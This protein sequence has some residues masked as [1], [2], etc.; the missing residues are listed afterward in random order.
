MESMNLFS[1][2]VGDFYMP[3]TFHLAFF[4]C[5]CHWFGFLQYSRAWMINSTDSLYCH[6]ER[7]CFRSF[8][9]LLSSLS[10]GASM[11]CALGL[12]ILRWMYFSPL[13]SYHRAWNRQIQLWWWYHL[14]SFLILSGSELKLTISTF[15]GL[16]MAVSSLPTMMSL[17]YSGLLAVVSF[18]LYSPSAFSAYCNSDTHTFILRSF[19][20]HRLLFW[21]F[22]VSPA[23]IP[24]PS[25]VFQRGMSVLSPP[26][27][28]E[29]LESGR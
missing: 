29:S 9:S 21:V 15:D 26:T 17:I 1:C 28:G 3:R 10:D 23:K 5:P 25:E 22:L 24:S 12:C 11:S 19:D 4:G 8:Q 16:L 2:N 14:N 20:I 6:P 27:A 13:K 7:F 18:F